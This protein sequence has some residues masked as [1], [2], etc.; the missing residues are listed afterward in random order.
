[1]KNN[2]KLA[3]G[4]L[5]FY[6]FP[7]NMTLPLASKRLTLTLASLD[8]LDFIHELNSFP[9]SAQFN[10]MGVPKNLEV[11]R[12]HVET[13]IENHSAER[14]ERYSFVISSGTEKLGT[15]GLNL[16]PHRYKGGEVWYTIHPEHWGKGIATEALNLVLDFGFNELKLH[17]IAA[18][19][20]VGNIGSIRV[21]EKVGMIREGRGRQILPLPSG[22]SDNFEYSILDSDPR[23]TL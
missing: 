7:P 6:I 17:R 19:C 18:G 14:I 23:V 2:L 11:T 16:K 9:E 13:C 12:A 22:W 8:D 5:I 20:A 1:M 10:T 15:I 3:H 21:L 4:Y